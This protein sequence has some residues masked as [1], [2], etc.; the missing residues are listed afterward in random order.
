MIFTSNKQPSQW[1][2]NFNEDDSLL[3][4]L[5]RIFDDALIF[6]LRGNS[7]RGKDCETFSL[8]TVNGKATN[9]ALAANYVFYRQGFWSFFLNYLLAFFSGLYVVNLGGVSV[10]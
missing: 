7:Y 3:C 5:D 10:G 9:A 2:Q 4:A 8:T 6:N 1:K